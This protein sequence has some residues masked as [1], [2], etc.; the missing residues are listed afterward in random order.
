[1][2]PFRERMPVRTMRRGDDVAV[3]ERTA[4]ADGAGLLADRDVEEAGQLAGTEPLLDLLLEAP[5]KEHFAQDVLQI[6]LREAR[7]LLDLRAHD[8]VT[9]RRLGAMGECDARTHGG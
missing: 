2:R 4:D 9:T 3:A 7:A 5:D 1:M 8:G 6:H